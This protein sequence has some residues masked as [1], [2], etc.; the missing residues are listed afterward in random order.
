MF[1]PDAIVDET[2]QIVKPLAQG[3]M[4]QVFLATHRR[5]GRDVAIKVLSPEFG[6]Q[7]EWV[8][9]LRREALILGKLRHPN[10]VQVLDF[11]VTADGA[12]YIAME[13]VEGPDLRTAMHDGR[14][15][16]AAEIVSIVRQVASALAAAHALDV[17]H[18][19]LKAENVVLT[20]V[21]GQLPVVK[22]ID[23]GISLWSAASRITAE[24]TVFGTPEYMA[25]EQAQGLRDQIDA[26]T[27]QFSLAVLAYTLIE[28]RP[29]FGGDTPVAVLYQVV[30]G[31]P[32]PLGP[33]S[34]WDASR[35]AEVLRRGMARD[36]EDRYPSVLE[37]AD[38]L[39]RALL[40]GGALSADV[41]I[42]PDAR[43]DD[44]EGAERVTSSH[45]TLKSR[46]PGTLRHV[47][48]AT[49]IALFVSLSMTSPSGHAM[50]VRGAGRARETLRSRWTQLEGRASA[51]VHAARP[52]GRPTVLRQVS[53][54]VY[55]ASTW[56][57]AASTTGAACSRT[58]SSSD[59]SR[60]RS[61]VA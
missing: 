11:N 33:F 41:P 43:P 50:L 37:F 6:A 30:N 60:T 45:P 13:L 22:V 23:F 9:R 28:N 26:R 54:Q 10:V 40:D 39:E 16:T 29:P 56:R 51:A 4:A 42:A 8:T 15:F 57:R 48:A 14:R 21:P 31:D 19:D 17:V 24:H 38:A 52:E 49:A 12:P 27:D 47:L 32:K 25:P 58:G 34:G 5:L 1:V 44:V 35:A 7:Q 46:R 20:E 36:R 55:S 3:G 53:L 59:S 18:R 2:Y 61:S